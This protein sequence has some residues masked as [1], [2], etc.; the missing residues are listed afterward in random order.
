MKGFDKVLASI[1]TN[2][3]EV[4]TF[5]EKDYYQVGEMI[6]GVVCIQGGKVDQKID[7]IHLAIKTTYSK[8]DLR[9]YSELSKIELSKSF[10]AK[11]EDN[12]NFHFSIPVPAAAPVTFERRNVWIQTILDVKSAM[13]PLDIDY[14]DVK[15]GPLAASIFEA[16]ESLGLIFESSTLNA[17]NRN[18]SI[19]LPFIQ[20]VRYHANASTFSENVHSVDV[21]LVPTMVDEM[22]IYLEINP[23]EN[24]TEVFSRSYNGDDN[25][26]LKLSVRT[27]DVPDMK[28]K[29]RS[30]LEIF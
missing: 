21:V 3:V 4:R 25:N 17:V 9:A 18:S 24:H 29:I 23:E 15:P 16:L 11:K 10:I 12:L 8:H 28:Q 7:S 26:H 22:M 20:E 27:T 1:G 13:D 30:L 14:I 19:A 6:H 5:L 2:G